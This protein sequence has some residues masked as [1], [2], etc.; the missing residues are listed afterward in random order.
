MCLE[1]SVSGKAPNTL[2]VTGV[3]A[4][5]QPSRVVLGTA[6]ISAVV[7]SCFLL[8]KQLPAEANCTVQYF[9][10]YTHIRKVSKACLLIYSLMHAVSMKQAAIAVILHCV[11]W[12]I[13]SAES[14]N[15]P[16]P[17]LEIGTLQ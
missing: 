1:T 9:Y 14:H 3:L 2:Q 13:L 12:S 7:I 10:M 5:M 4:H 6:V 17:M 8:D 15:D 16:V 11:H